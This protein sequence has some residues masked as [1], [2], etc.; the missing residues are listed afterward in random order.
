METVRVGVFGKGDG[1]KKKWTSCVVGGGG[2]EEEGQKKNRQK[3]GTESKE[4]RPSKTQH[5]SVTE[6]LETLTLN[7]D[8]WI[9]PQEGQLTWEEHVF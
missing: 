1:K 6:G 4:E 9:C 8:Y 5:D 2:Q 3:N 7:E